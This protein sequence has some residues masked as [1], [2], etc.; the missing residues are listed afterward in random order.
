MTAFHARPA[1]LLASAALAAA[2][3]LFAPLASA[4]DGAQNAPLGAPVP[5]GPRER[6][7]DPGTEAPAETQPAAPPPT[8]GSRAPVEIQTLGSID[9]DSVGTMD[10]A[11]GGFP[12]DLWRGLDRAQ[13]AKLLDMLPDRM[14]SPTM[15]GLAHRLLLSR[16]TAPRGERTGKSLLARRV[17]VLYGMGDAESA[18]ALLRNAPPGHGEDALMR[19]EV[20]GHFLLNDN[21][22][23]C[24]QVRAHA[25]ERLNAYWQQASAY[26]LALAGQPDKAALLADILA[27]RGNA[28]PSAFFAA[29][30]SFAGMRSAEV[31]SLASPAALHIS[32]MRA[33]N[34]QLPP[35]ALGAG[36]PALLRAIAVSPNA[37]LD[38]RLEAAERALADG[39]LPPERLREI[40]ASVPT[41]RAGGDQPLTFAEKSWG[42][43][44]RALLV[45]AAAAQD[46]A[47]AKAE[48][49]QRGYRLGRER[50]G[51]TPFL[52]ASLPQLVA[53]APAGELMWFAGDAG[54]A[55]FAAGRIDEARRWYE[56]PSGEAGANA[57]AKAAV[58][59]LWPLAH[60]VGVA[61][62]ADAASARAA[63]W[64]ARAAAKDPAA[65]G[66][67]QRLFALLE[68]LG[69]TVD[70][71]LWRAV[72]G[73]G[74]KVTMNAPQAALRHALAAAARDGRLG[75]GVAL[76]LA[77]LGAE[78]PEGAGIIAVE[79]AVRALKGLGLEKEARAVALEAAVAGGL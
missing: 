57:E 7:P 22:S 16:V 75:E 41:D 27:E 35:D 77:I 28:V 40:Y 32:M 60:L 8:I 21:A 76:T 37:R 64:E 13:V 70:P 66:R 59:S 46:A 65:A 44:A 5:L 52:M 9:P 79:D 62:D 1:G 69:E 58:E 56:F 50:G 42:P 4:Q 33:A 54:A 11:Q 39:A 55:L 48:V 10:P 38:V 2:L 53:I 51:Y 73:D 67:A 19:A 6:R 12:V 45:R 25:H 18:L 14:P 26:C 43:E 20:E 3:A 23:A 29:M 30:D 71:G 31:A 17:G 74:G 24:R 34:L 47:T 72:L 36:S 68:A 61:G 78:G 63:W 49:L 15:R